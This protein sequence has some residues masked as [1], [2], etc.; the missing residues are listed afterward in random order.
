[1]SWC[2]A[3]TARLDVW[4]LGL[5][6]IFRILWVPCLEEHPSTGCEQWLRG[7]L[8]DT[9]LVRAPDTLDLIVWIT[10]V[11]L[12]EGNQCRGRG[13]VAVAGTQDLIHVSHSHSGFKS[14]LC[15]DC[16]KNNSNKN[17]SGTWPFSLRHCYN[18]INGD[19]SETPSLGTVS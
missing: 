3:P 15:T 14:K 7:H 2:P 8:S 19:L 4:E 9:V 13:E 11:P 12:L 1:M 18:A 5:K 6:G 17:H 10:E 16:L